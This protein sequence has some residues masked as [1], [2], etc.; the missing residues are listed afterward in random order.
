MT[1]LP[2]PIDRSQT[3]SGTC[4]NIRPLEIISL[5]LSKGIVLTRAVPHTRDLKALECLTP[6]FKRTR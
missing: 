5:P 2:K 4:F 1:D 3:S 6:K